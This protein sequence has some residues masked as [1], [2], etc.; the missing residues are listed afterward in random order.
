MGLSVKATEQLVRDQKEQGEPEAAGNGKTSRT[1]E[2][3]TTHVRGI[4]DE[5]RQRFA[6][7]VEIKLRA[8]DKG[9]IVLRFDSN[10]D[11][12]RILEVLRK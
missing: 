3:K 8:K 9:H 2:E 11:F 5:L 4:E 1:G 12:E 7:Q 6:T 10:D